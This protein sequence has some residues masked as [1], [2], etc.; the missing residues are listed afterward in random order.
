MRSKARGFAVVL[1]TTLGL[2]CFGSDAAAEMSAKEKDKERTDVRKASTSTLNALYTAVPASRKV[3]EASAG[4]ATFSNF[5][6]K[7]LV[8]GSG[9][10]KGDAYQG[11][12][13]VSPGVWVYQ[14]TDKGVALELTAKGTKYYKD[15]DLN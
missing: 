3:V 10:G 4:Y 1:C 15:D 8:A 9:S 14:L 5:G 6:M 2:V 7:I 13:S 12:I 11:A